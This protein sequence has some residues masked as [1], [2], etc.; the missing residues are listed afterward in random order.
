MWVWWVGVCVFGGHGSVSERGWGWETEG[1]EGQC[2]A[3]RRGYVWLAILHLLPPSL[4][5]SCLLPPTPLISSLSLSPSLTSNCTSF[6]FLLIFLVFVH[7]LIPFSI[8]DLNICWKIR[9]RRVQEQRV[10]IYH[11]IIIQ[12]L[13]NLLALLCMKIPKKLIKISGS[14]RTEKKCRQGRDTK[15]E[16]I[17]RNENESEF[18]WD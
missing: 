17:N 15:E 8:L 6:S 12:F 1:R 16:K 18:A 14:K 7:F 10:Y 9:A 3:A 5:P 4:P 13:H 11:A 2:V